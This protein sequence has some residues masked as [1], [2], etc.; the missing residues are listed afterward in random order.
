M[1]NSLHIDLTVDILPDSPKDVTGQDNHKGVLEEVRE[2]QEAGAVEQDTSQPEAVGA[3]GEK[4][5]VVIDREAGFSD[6]HQVR[7]LQGEGCPANT[8]RCNRCGEQGHF[9]RSTLCRE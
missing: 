3:L 2:D 6:S 1:F 8:R 5:V 4:R 9:R 7:P